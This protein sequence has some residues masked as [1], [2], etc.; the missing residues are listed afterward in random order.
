MIITQE[1]RSVL[2]RL[3]PDNFETIIEKDDVFVLLDALDD[4]YLELL[5]DGQEP[6]K[7]SEECE[8]IR[9]TIHFQNTHKD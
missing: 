6:T 8:R 5:D 7:E 9:D 3:L 2:R 4:L 1:Q